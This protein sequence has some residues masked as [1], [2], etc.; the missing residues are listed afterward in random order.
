MSCHVDDLFSDAFKD[1]NQ[2][3]YRKYRCDDNLALN[4]LRLNYGTILEVQE[5]V[6]GAGP[7][8]DVQLDR[9]LRQ[10]MEFYTL[11]AEPG[12]VEAHATNLESLSPC[13]L[14]RRKIS[15]I[16]KLTEEF[17]WNY[18]SRNPKAARKY[19]PE[20]ETKIVEFSISHDD[21]RSRYHPNRLNG[22]L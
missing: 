16:I 19:W 5:I 13:D 6:M 8:Y 4:D 20:Y 7:Q 3:L 17:M 15:M 10:K 14:L 21:L 11:F 12:F 22:Q 18:F 2:D 9:K 1:P